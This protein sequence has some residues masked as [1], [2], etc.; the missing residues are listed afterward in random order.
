MQASGRRLVACLLVVVC[1]PTTAEADGAS[2]VCAARL[3]KMESL[4]G[5]ARHAKSGWIV[6]APKLD[7][8]AVPTAALGRPL[9]FKGIVVQIGRQSV[10]LDERPIPGSDRTAQL[11]ALSA[12]IETLWNNYQLLHPQG[13][14]PNRRLYVILD[15]RLTVK[16]AAEVINAIGRRNRLVPLAAPESWAPTVAPGPALEA[17]LGSFRAEVDAVTSA[18][19][20]SVLAHAMGA[21]KGSVVPPRPG[22][23]ETRPEDEFRQATHAH[24]QQLLTTC[25]C[26]GA[27]LDAVENVLLKE[28]GALE[29]TLQHLPI[30]LTAARGKALVAPADAPVM[31]VLA[32]YAAKTD[33]SSD[34]VVIRLRSSAH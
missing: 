31:P 22:P 25:D 23:Q 13:P 18:S 17:R 32:A 4:L 28:A 16:E 21:C 15:Q 12:E 10:W 26:Q 3:A 1:V 27:N 9:D 11:K 29:L 5:Q 20:F 14:P 2:K 24:I 6:F 30:E 7:G 34:P 19:F 8:L 33:T